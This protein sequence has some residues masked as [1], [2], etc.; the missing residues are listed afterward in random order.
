MIQFTYDKIL[1]RL[2]DNLS[3]RLDNSGM[4]FY[5]TNQRIL[6]AIAEE[7]SEQ[8]RYNE[9]LTNEAKW[10][11]A[12]NISSLIAQSDFFGYTPHRKI[13]A[14]G[15]LTVSSS[16][17]FNGAWAY[18]IDIPKFSQ[19][20][21]G[22][23]FYTS[24][25]SI[26]LFSANNSIQVPVIQGLVR[27][28]TFPTSMFS[29]IELTNHMISVEN[30]SIE[31]EIL[32]VR[33]NNVIWKKIG[34]FGESPSKDA[35][36]YKVTNTFDFSGITIQF[37]DGLVSKK[38]VSG[39]QI[40]VTYLETEG[41]L[42]EV[43]RT[44]SVTKV[45]SSFK[46]IN[47]TPKILYCK[48][49]EE[50]TG[51]REIEDIETIRQTAPV[52]FKT[53]DTLV[54]QQDYLAALLATLI[55]D[56]VVVWGEAEQNMDENQPIG[57]FIPLTEN[58]IFVSALVISDVTKEASPLIQGQIN[59]IQNL[60]AP[61]KSLTDI[62][63]FVD[64]KITFLE[65]HCRV[66]FDKQ[67]YTP[68][69]VR[70]IVTEALEEKYAISNPSRS[71][72]ENLYFSQY[73]AFINELTP[74]TYHTT[75][76]FLSQVEVF[77]EGVGTSYRLDIDLGFSGIRKGSVKLSIRSID[78]TLSSNHPYSPENE[79]NKLNGGWFL[80]ATDDGA[81]EFIS[82]PV[83]TFEG[84]PDSG[85]TFEIEP[86]VLTEGFD[87]QTGVEPGLTVKKGIPADWHD[88]LQV[89]VE[90]QT[91]DTEVDVVPRRRN[92]IFS[93]SRVVVYTED[94]VE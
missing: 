92:Q 21:N 88:S 10:S 23:N 69:S 83:P 55:P 33:V 90:F 29:D 32:E 64:P 17:T 2:Q 48:N 82:E 7:L 44:N 67:S 4:L 6:E 74:V 22:E 53:G 50:I 91:G 20:S 37:G 41:E 46:D 62:I 43:L 24:Y 47:N 8:M 26:K 73:Y 72:K 19:F 52:T 59:T 35:L 94:R 61:K 58:L 56:K 25:E 16:P 93:L 1:E 31:N 28:E 60:L 79:V 9:Y 34:Y 39:D 38:I 57:S 89:K 3:K 12:Q 40:S 78:E 13:G 30:D 54:T 77:K 14:K 85:E 36:L 65:M 70:N 15:E 51:G 11:T 42:G 49:T 68:D 63:N 86:N 80:I 18:Q 87:Y 71:F 45:I 84:I 75:T 81:G 27:T 76:L 66:Y 5:S